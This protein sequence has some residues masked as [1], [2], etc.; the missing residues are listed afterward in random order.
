MIIDSISL[1]VNCTCT[2]KWWQ[3]SANQSAFIRNRMHKNYDTILF[4]KCENS[5]IYCIKSSLTTSSLR[6]F[7]RIHVWIFSCRSFYIFEGFAQMTHFFD[8]NFVV[9]RS[10]IRTF[11]SKSSRD[12]WCGRRRTK[13]KEG[14]SMPMALKDMNS[15]GLNFCAL[16]SNLMP[17]QCDCSSQFTHSHANVDSGKILSK[18]YYYSYCCCCCYCDLNFH[19][20]QL[21]VVSRARPNSHCESISFVCVIEGE[22]VG[23][24]KGNS[25]TE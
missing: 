5:W 12:M 6:N 17:F 4:W 7:H 20:L 22:R 10:C 1:F 15:Q 25:S 2:R 21:C 11:T 8:N 23:E 14:R 18:H 16:I 24:R 19:S 13:K 3:T 9:V